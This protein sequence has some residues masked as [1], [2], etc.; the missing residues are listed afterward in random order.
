[1]KALSVRQ[2]FAD[3]IAIGV[4]TIEF[5]TWSTDHRGKLL[6]CASS[7]DPGLWLDVEADGAVE[8]LPLPCGVML[9]VVKLVNIR[10]MTRADAK[11]YDCEFDP[12]TL[13]WEL[14]GGYAVLPE[15]VT[16]K[17]HLFE[18]PDDLIV[19][20]PEG[21]SWMD[22]DYPNRNKRRPKKWAE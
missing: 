14:E 15:P 19:K 10:Q 9:C 12:G 1:M 18:V 11:D 17:L 5:R 6:I 8:Q 4:K 3:Q 13:A 21:D 16:G 2:P 7:H 20:M 22:Y